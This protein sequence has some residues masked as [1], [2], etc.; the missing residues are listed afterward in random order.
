M[1]SGTHIRGN[2]W[3]V[4]CFVVGQP[5]FGLEEREIMTY[6]MTKACPICKRQLTKKMPAETVQC[7]CGKHIWQG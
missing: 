2:F 3:S 6:V 4:A 7:S 5:P 1:L